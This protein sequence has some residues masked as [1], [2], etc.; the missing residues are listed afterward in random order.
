MNGIVSHLIN[1]VL[2][3]EGTTQPTGYTI[4][5]ESSERTTQTIQQETSSEEAGVQLTKNTTQAESS[6]R[7]TQTIQQETSSEEAGVQLTETT[8]QA[9]SSE[10][11]VQ[12]A[13]CVL[14]LAVILSI[15]F[16]TEAMNP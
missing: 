7:T 11:R 10:G 2:A 3:S 14:I 13:R 5:A 4:P 6:E 9:E 12:P 8:T 16:I 1:T 15:V